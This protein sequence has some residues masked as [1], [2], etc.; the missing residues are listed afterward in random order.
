MQ[1]AKGSHHWDRCN[2]KGRDWDIAK[3]LSPVS[4][5]GSRV[6]SLNKGGPY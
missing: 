6:G 5:L 2:R 3:Y 4:I 1:V